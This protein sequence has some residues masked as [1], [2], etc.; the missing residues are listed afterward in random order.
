ML[1]SLLIVFLILEKSDHFV[2]VSVNLAS[3]TVTCLFH[4]QTENSENY[5][6]CSIVYGP[7]RENCQPQNQGKIASRSTSGSNIVLVF[8]FND[9][10]HF[11]PQEEY[12]FIVTASNGSFTAQIEGTTIILGTIIQNVC[13]GTIN[14]HESVDRYID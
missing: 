10:E 5:N 3:K 8:P 14:F 4:Q 11:Q 7:S 9:S 2:D 12:C 13:H 6:Y 1:H